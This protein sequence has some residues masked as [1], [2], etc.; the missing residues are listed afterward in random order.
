MVS[1]LGGIPLTLIALVA[2]CFA[3]QHAMSAISTY[4]RGGCPNMMV[5]LGDKLVGKSQIITWSE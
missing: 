5:R 2:P 1:A 4:N 3:A